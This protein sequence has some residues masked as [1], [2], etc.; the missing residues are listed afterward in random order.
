MIA[1]EAT[2]TSAV[3]GSPHA[4]ALLA[5]RLRRHVHVPVTPDQVIL[6]MPNAGG[7]LLTES[8]TALSVQVVVADELAVKRFVATLHGELTAVSAASDYRATFGL[9]WRRTAHVPVALR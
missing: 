2:I 4:I 1:I 8:T 9:D 3:A 6:Q 7:V 5:T